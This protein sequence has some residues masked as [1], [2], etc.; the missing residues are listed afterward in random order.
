MVLVFGLG[1]DAAGQDP[2]ELAKKSGIAGL[3]ASAIKDSS[4][5]TWFTRI[6]TFVLVV[7]AL[8]SGSRT[9]VKSV[10]AVYAIIWRVPFDKLRGT[11]TKGIIT[12]GIITGVLIV[13][14]IE[15]L[16]KE[17]SVLL[18]VVALVLEVG[19]P[20]GLWLLC[21]VKVLPSAPGTTWRDL[22][23]GALLF[24][25]GVQMLHVVTVVWIARS[26]ESKSER[27]GALGVART[28][29]FWAY[30]LGRLVTASA[31]LSAVLWADKQNAVGTEETAP[32]SESGIDPTQIDPTDIEPTGVPLTEGDTSE[33]VAVVESVFAPPSKARPGAPPVP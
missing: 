23:P 13:A 20:T 25:V 24:G 33:E 19:V 2:V 27:Y 5:A 11:T 21:T 32:F 12:I 8:V 17:Q 26:L 29:L 28:I 3:A 1:A 14:Q 18:W 31:S 7:W 4:T 16:L 10:R 22:W 6:A 9:L 30:L 15:A